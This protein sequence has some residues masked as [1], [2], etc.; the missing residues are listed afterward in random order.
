MSE[1]LSRQIYVGKVLSVHWL[2]GAVNTGWSFLTTGPDGHVV[3]VHSQLF[4]VTYLL[5]QQVLN[6]E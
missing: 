2:D 6:S 1:I 4:Y 5:D 3:L